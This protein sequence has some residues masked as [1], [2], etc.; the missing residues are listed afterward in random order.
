MIQLNKGTERGHANHGWLESG[1][2]FVC[3]LLRPG[4]NGRRQPARHQ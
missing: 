1:T 4:Q 3:G 2:V